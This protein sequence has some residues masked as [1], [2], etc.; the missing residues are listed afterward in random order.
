M[1]THVAKLPIKGEVGDKDYSS[2]EAI[3]HKMR[4]VPGLSN[5]K[6][7]DMLIRLKT[8]NASTQKFADTVEI[9]Y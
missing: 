3:A 5:E 1:G 7:E 9:I 8:T 6:I 2:V 4:G